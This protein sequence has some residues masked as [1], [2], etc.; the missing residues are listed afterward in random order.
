MR[1]T[2]AHFHYIYTWICSLAFLTR[3]KLHGLLQSFHEW[4]MK[5]GMMGHLGSCWGS[6][7]DAGVD[8]PIRSIYLNGWCRELQTLTGLGSLPMWRYGGAE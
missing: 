4:Q 1:V 7:E 5:G 8:G 6:R 3:V 2:L